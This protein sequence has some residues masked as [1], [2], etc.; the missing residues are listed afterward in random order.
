MIDP[1]SWVPFIAVAAG[2]KSHYVSTVALDHG[3][4]SKSIEAIFEL[5]ILSTLGSVN[6]FSDLFQAGQFP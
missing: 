1:G 5:P 2:V 3:S 4:L 6:D